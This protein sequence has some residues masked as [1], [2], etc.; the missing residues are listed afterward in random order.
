MRRASG[1]LLAFAVATLACTSARQRGGGSPPTLESALEREIEVREDATV[2]TLFALLNV[3]GY[4]EENREAGM[5]PVRVRVREALEKNLNPQLRK[6]LR[7]FYAQ[8]AQEADTWSYSV[9]AMATSGPPSF[10]PTREWTDELVQDARFGDLAPLHELLRRFYQS[11][12]VEELYAPVRPAY[13]A[14]IGD[15]RGAIHRE[16]AAAL[17]Y[18]RTQLTELTASGE[19]E[20]P[21]VI[22]NL[23]DSYFRAT[24]FVLE[25][26]FLSLEGPQEKVGYN[27]HEFLHAVTNPAVYGAALP[28]MDDLLREAR[29]ALEEPE[30]RYTSPAAF[31]DENLVRA[32]SLRYR[33]PEHPEKEPSL[34]K[35]MLEEWRSGYVLERYFWEQLAVYERQDA[36]LRSF[37]GP[38]LG[39]LD[40]AAELRR[41]REARSSTAP[42]TGS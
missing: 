8:H 33:V 30:S 7:A 27:P 3:A 2:F 1:F 34:E 42:H 38:M 10:T 22:P 29:A 41:W 26:R 18:S 20:H 40:P 15:Y 25:N 16:T 23:L 12:R 21:R 37:C 4:D 13:L 39:R 17:A 36:D 24:S 32:L 14:V 11:A 31:V 5:H 35:A 28:A 9:V 19:R 6:D